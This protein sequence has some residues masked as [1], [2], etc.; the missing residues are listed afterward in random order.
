MF[1]FFSSQE[2]KMR[3]NAANWLE[4]ADKV[5][6]VRRD[7]LPAAEAEA[8][9]RRRDDLRGALKAR[10]DAGKLK[11]L[12]EA[13]EESLKHSGGAVYPKTAL[14]DNVE[15]LVV[16][17]IVIFGIRAYFVQPFKIPTN[18][19]W[20]SYY[21]MTGVNWPPGKPLPGPVSRVFR[22]LAFGAI[23][24][25]AVAPTDGEVSFLVEP[26][27][28]DIIPY[29]LK[30]GRTWLIFPTDVHEYTFFVDGLPTSVDV[31]AD[32]GQGTEAGTGTFEDLFVQTYFGTWDAY[33]AHLRE[34]FRQRQ[35]V[36]H[37]FTADERTEMPAEALLVPTGRSVRRGDPVM[38]FDI[39]TGDQLFVD[40]FTYNF[41]PP[42]PGQ[43]FVFRTDHIAKI[44]KQDYFIKRLVGVPG[45]TITI[46]P[47]QIYR[48]GRPITGAR[49][50]TLNANRVPPYT[51]YTQV[52]P[53]PVDPDPALPGDAS[54]TVPPR[55][56]FPMG[57]N[58]AN[59]FDGRYW[60][61]VDAD[62]VVGRP[63]FVYYPFTPRW[64]VAH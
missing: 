22:L 32:F 25:E 64:G 27:N 19:M 63:L 45:D 29:T 38:R 3:R 4:V 20:P 48:N 40:R 14:V 44:G 9:A 8:L 59:S 46:R 23:R 1:G 13:L 24:H 37:D 54:I 60:G 6:A 33:R 61:F 41:F 7:V 5:W 28:T 58:S 15:F 50:F 18:S 49:A 62:D 34:A 17:A 56:Y 11:L 16:A 31:P 57:D 10:A 51:G 43:G 2:S 35:V 42:R 26:G 12:I 36:A 52:F 39:L 55:H 53:G 30:R 21:G 47:P